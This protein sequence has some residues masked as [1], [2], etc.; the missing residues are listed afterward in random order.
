MIQLNRQYINYLVCLSFILIAIIN[1]SF[2]QSNKSKCPVVSVSGP[3]SNVSVGYP[4]V[5][6]ANVTGGDAAVTPIYN[7]TISAGSITSGQGTSA[8]TVDVAEAESGQ[9]ITTTVDIGGY[10]RECSPSNSY[11]FSVGK[12]V[13]TRKVDEYMNIRLAD[14]QARLDNYA[15]ELQMDPGAKGYIIS[16]AGI[17]SKPNIAKTNVE[18]AKN[19]LVSMRGMS[20]DRIITVDGGYRQ[21]EIT[22]LYLVPEGAFAPSAEPTVDPLK[23]TP[24][25]KTPTPVKKVPVKT[26]SKIKTK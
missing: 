6:S 26:V 20:E 16:Y 18:R 21:E 11:T 14:E 19:Y 12:K 9:S 8:I 4:A 24:I 7:W 3:S 23:I 15:N 1:H 17:K 25:K 2:A 13:I 10:S 22:E 5:F